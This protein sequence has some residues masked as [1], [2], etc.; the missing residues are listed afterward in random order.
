MI[1]RETLDAS[2]T[3]IITFDKPVLEIAIS[4]STSNQLE[5]SNDGVTYFFVGTNA[6][7]NHIKYLTG[8]KTV[9]VKNPNTTS[10][11]VTL[12]VEKEGN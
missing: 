6:N 3:K 5:I 7:I 8:Q 4:H 9:Y 1:K 11:V 10:I 12:L 2:E